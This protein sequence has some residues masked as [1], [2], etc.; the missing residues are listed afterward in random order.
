MERVAMLESWPSHPCTA[1]ASYVIRG[2][3]PPSEG[4]RGGLCEASQDS[5]GG[6]SI[7][8]LCCALLPAPACGCPMAGWAQ[9]SQICS[10]PPKKP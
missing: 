2:P 3:L 7:R 5:G 8:R 6:E 9:R 1:R 10:P 4:H